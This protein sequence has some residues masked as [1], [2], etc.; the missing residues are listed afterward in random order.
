[1]IPRTF[2]MLFLRW[3]FKIKQLV[4][5]QSKYEL[6]KYI[7]HMYTQ[8]KKKY[9]VREVA[10]GIILK[11]DPGVCVGSFQTDDTTSRGFKKHVRAY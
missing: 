9:N 11:Y 6:C 3:N 2:K 1:M 4:P 10:D 7:L 8:F 5:Y